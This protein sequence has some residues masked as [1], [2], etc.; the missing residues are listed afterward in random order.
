MININLNYHEVASWIEEIT[1][2]L[3]DEWQSRNDGGWHSHDPSHKSDVWTT[4]EAILWLLHADAA[5]YQRSIEH[6]LAFLSEQQNTEA[7]LGKSSARVDGGWGYRRDQDSDS[8]AT[9]LAILAFARYLQVNSNRTDQHLPRLRLATDWLVKN[10]SPDGGFCLRPGAGRPLAFNTCWG[11]LALA[12]SQAIQDL[13]NPVVNNLLATALGLVFKSKQTN[14][15]GRII[16][17]PPDAIGTSYC[18]YLL[19]CMQQTSR[20]SKERVDDELNRGM[21]LRNNQSN[22]GSWEVGLLQSP[23]EATSWAIITLLG[24][25]DDPESPRILTAIKYLRDLYVPQKGWPAYPGQPPMIW[26]TFY[27]CAALSSYIDVVRQVQAPNG[28]RPSRLGKK[29]FIVHGHDEFIR[30]ETKELIAGHGL[31]PIVLDEQPNRGFTI[32]EKFEHYASQDGVD[33]AVVLCTIDD[34]D[35]TDGVMTPRPNVILELGWFLAKL[36]RQRIC[37]VSEGDVSLP[38]DLKGVLTINLKKADWKERLE[39]ELRAVGLI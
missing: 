14:G 12:E 30:K 21:W 29:V 5:K 35:N 18:M 31:T 32:I 23:V 15:W 9:A 3:V 11:S 7:N 37:L 19:Q 1:Q 10:V 24:C 28:I 16:G 8:T 27:V 26:A 6:G 38:S 22:N 17:D 20:L 2:K 34:M 39:K 13:E 25:N 33:Y 36:G 4:S